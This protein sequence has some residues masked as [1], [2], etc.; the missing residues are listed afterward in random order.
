MHSACVGQRGCERFLAEDVLSRF[1]GGEYQFDVFDRFGADVH[2]V[3][4]RRRDHFRRIRGREF[5]AG[6]FGEGSCAG[7]VT[8]ARGKVIDV[9]R[10]SVCS[11]ARD[12]AN[13]A[14]VEFA[15]E[16]ATD[17]ANAERHAVT[18]SAS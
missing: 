12:V 2:R 15:D 1:R 14:R 6:V 18:L 4:V 7:R 9:E 17:Q 13:V 5:A 11:R 16:A 8:V 10:C 3:D